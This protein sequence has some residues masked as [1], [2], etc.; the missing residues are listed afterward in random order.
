[1]S[2]PVSGSFL[3][4]DSSTG[5]LRPLVPES[6]R[7]KV[8]DNIHKVSHPG[9]RA[10]KRL[11]SRSF[12]W[13]FLSKD[14]NLW[15]ESCLDCQRSKIQSHVKAPVLQIPVPGRRFS[16]IHVD[17]VGPLPQS[18]G[19]SYLF[20]IIDRTSRW[21]EAVP[22]LH[23]TAEECAKVL[24]R[25][26]IPVFGVPAVITSDRGAQFTSS[27]WSS[28]CKFLGIIH[29]PTTSF[30]PQ[31]NGIVE[32]FH[33]QLKVS[34]RARLAGTD[35]FAHL[36]L[37]LLGL[38]SVPRE[39]S[40]VSASEALFG[41]PL[42][43]PGEFLDSPELP[44][45]EFLQ[46]VQ[47]VLKNNPVSP[48]HHKSTTVVPSSTVPSSLVCSLHIFPRRLVHASAVSAVQRSLQSTVPNTKVFCRL[49]WFQTRLC[50]CR[51]FDT[52]SFGDSS[53]TSA[54]TLQR[55][56]SSSENS[57]SDTPSSKPLAPVPLSIIT[58]LLTSLKKDNKPSKR[59]R[60][61]PEVDLRF[62]NK[63]ESKTF[64]KR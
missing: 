33:R 48:P 64:C 38:R 57:G 31:S 53:S 17:L 49:D 35:W 37:V 4:C 11:V 16:H 13:E 51:L 29:S 44:S 7:R 62:G 56:S 26:W 27:I 45:E 10:S 42:V 50:L 58:K 40:S 59:V 15:S 21:P 6:M 25:S 3:L 63:T 46:R 47:Q 52:L 12:V 20:T 61:S 2:V 34:L 14:V 36:P 41:A 54:S 55:S 9:K 18:Q 24:L 23:T 5:V 8:F 30:H 1:M 43:L 32:R 28:L 22:V 60:M 39:D 19:F